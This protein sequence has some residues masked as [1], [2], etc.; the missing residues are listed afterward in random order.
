[1]GRI[2]GQ[3]NIMSKPLTFVRFLVQIVIP[4]QTPI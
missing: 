3:K 2:M 1:M 4:I